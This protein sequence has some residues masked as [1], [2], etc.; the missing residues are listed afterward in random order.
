MTGAYTDNCAY[1]NEGLLLGGVTRRTLGVKYRNSRQSE[2]S[3]CARRIYGNFWLHE[4]EEIPSVI[5]LRKFILLRSIK[6]PT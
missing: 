6:G 1:D 2:G 5:F 3:N 4:V